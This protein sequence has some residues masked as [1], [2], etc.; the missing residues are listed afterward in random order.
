MELIIVLAVCGV[1]IGVGFWR[2]EREKAAERA[3][4]WSGV[5]ERI[6][7]TDGLRIPR[8]K[9]TGMNHIQKGRHIVWIYYRRDDGEQGRFSS[10]PPATGAV[11]RKK[12]ASPTM[13]RSN[14]TGR[15]DVE[16]KN[17][18]VNPSRGWREDA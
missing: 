14:V 8:V 2:M 5:I 9:T 10:A 3:R 12:R 15:S 18:R 11:G 16:S 4:P 1:L 6:D 7:E 13:K 17:P